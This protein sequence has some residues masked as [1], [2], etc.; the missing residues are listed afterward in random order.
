[1]GT[2]HEPM[3]IILKIVNSWLL[4]VISFLLIWWYKTDKVFTPLEETCIITQDI[5]RLNESVRLATYYAQCKKRVLHKIN[6]E[7]K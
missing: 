2:Y 6:W 1:M 5:S 7:G 3:S 4:A